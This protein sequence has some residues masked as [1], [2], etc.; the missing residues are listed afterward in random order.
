M[1]RGTEIASWNMG[2]VIFAVPFLFLGARVI[3]S[4]ADLEWAGLEQGGRAWIFRCSV[5]LIA[6]SALTLLSFDVCIRAKFASRCG[7]N[8]V[9]KAVERSSPCAKPPQ[10]MAKNSAKN[11]NGLDGAHLSR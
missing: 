2:V 7:G 1:S 9:F 10:G 4:S 6:C 8:P 3:R 11:K 5:R